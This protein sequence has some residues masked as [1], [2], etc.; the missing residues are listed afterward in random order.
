MEGFHC[1]A[2]TVGDRGSTD[3]GSTECESTETV[4][5]RSRR[6]L[7]HLFHLLWFLFKLVSVRWLRRLAGLCFWVH[8]F[9]FQGFFL[10]FFCCI[11]GFIDGS[12]TR[13]RL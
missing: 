3:R 4:E 10:G 12:Q 11:L 2:K 7:L 8:L 13:W 9:M 1:L 6:K 5:L